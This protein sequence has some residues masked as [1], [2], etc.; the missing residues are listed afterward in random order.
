M[1]KTAAA[2]FVL[3]PLGL[4]LA[5]CGATTS[6]ITRPASSASPAT[7]S[8]PGVVAD[9]TSAP[10]Y[11]LSIRPASIALACG[12]AGVGVENITWTTWTT[13]PATGQGTF[14]LKLCKPNCADGKI[15][16]YPVAVKLSA[17]RTSAQGPWFSRLTVTWR[18]AHP[19]ILTPG[20]YQLLPP[21]N[22]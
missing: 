22:P 1:L 10:P 17:V 4:L 18:S 2:G 13:S 21:G 5:A 19:P 8:L 12:D 16:T 9:C 3:L 6:T 15:G 11:Q 14:W 20:S 7:G